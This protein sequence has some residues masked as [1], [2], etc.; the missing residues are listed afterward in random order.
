MR[1]YSELVEI[2]RAGGSL[3]I[4]PDSTYAA[5]ELVRIAEGVKQGGGRLIIQAAGR[6]DSG[7]LIAVCQAAPGQVYVYE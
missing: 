3:V 2:A 7:D 5:E 4:P 6:Y 1:H